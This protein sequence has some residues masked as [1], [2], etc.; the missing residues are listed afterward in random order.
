VG[1]DDWEF[2]PGWQTRLDT[3]AMAQIARLRRMFSALPWWQLVPAT[4]DE[5]VTGGRGTELTTDE[6]M[7]VLDNDY[8]TAARTA[9]GRL[10]VVY[11]PT[12]R[13]ISIRREAVPAATRATWVDPTS[14]ARHPVRMASAFT[15]PGTNAAGDP[16]WI[17]LL[18]S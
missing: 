9:D 3:R 13:T 6:P 8:A 10:A 1:S 2:R 16:D 7:D 14:G 12:R 15:S 17:L 5:L 4:G 18:T 11:L